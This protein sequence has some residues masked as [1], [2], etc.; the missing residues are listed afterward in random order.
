MANIASLE[1]RYSANI[2]Q[3]DR[4]LKRLQTLNKR[5]TDRVLTDHK[6][7]VRDV[8][9]AWAKADIGGALNKSLGSGLGSLK[10]QLMGSIAAITS[11]AGIAAA[12]GLADTFNRFSNSLKI[13]GA[14]GANL[15]IIQDR[16]FA[17]A[18]RHGVQ[19]ESLGQLYGRV[20]QSAKELGV[21]QNQILTVTDA[22]AAA[23]RVSGQPISAASGAMLQFAQSIGSGTVRAEEFNSMVEG[24][25]PLVQ[26]AA[27]ASSKYTGSV[28]RMRAA[29]LEGKLSSKE[30]F[31]L[32][33]AGSAALEAKA[34]RA[35]LTVAQSF[36]ALKNKLIEAM[37][38]TNATWGL[39]DRLSEALAWLS[40][41][42]DDVA[43]ALGA[44]AIALST[45]LAPAIGRAA[46]AMA[47]NT[48]AMATN[49]VAAIA[50]IP[51]QLAFAAALNGTTRAAAAATFGL[52]LLTSATGIGLVITAVT[53]ALGLFA[54]QSYK[55]AEATR[56]IVD[57]VREKKAALDEAKKAADKARVE[58]GNLSQ[59]EMAA[60]TATASLTGQVDLLTTSYG[61]MAV[62]AK[63][64]RL[65]VLAL[66]FVRADSNAKKLEEEARRVENRVTRR[67]SVPVGSAD[68]RQPVPAGYHE[69]IRGSVAVD[70]AVITA[71]KDAADARAVADATLAE[72]ERVK[73]E[74]AESFA[75]APV[76]STST[77]KG[78]K[79][80]GTSAADRAKNSEE[81]IERAERALRDARRGQAV[82]ASEQYVVAVAALADDK[83]MAV[84]AITRRETEGEITKAA[85]DRLIELENQ[86][87]EARLT[88]A[89]NARQ[90]ELD[91]AALELQRY[92]TDNQIEAAKLDVEELN[93]KASLADNRQERHDYERQALEAQQRADRLMFDAEQKSYALQLKKNEVDQA[94]IDRLVAERETNFVRGQTN[95]TST[96]TGRHK[97]ENGPQNLQEWITS[98]GK[99][100]AAGESFNQKLFAIAE[101]GFNAITSGIT[102]AIMGAKT[103]G[104]AFQDVA[105]SV[106]AALIEM[107][108]KFVFFEMLGRAFGV[109][110]LGRAALGIPTV[111][112]AGG[113]PK[114]GSNAMGTRFWGGGPTSI[115]EKGDEIITLPTGS[116]VIPANLV[117]QAVSARPRG[118]NAPIYNMTTVVNA[119]GA[120]M[121]DHIREEIAQAYVMA[122]RDAKQGTLADLA[123]R[124]RNR[125]R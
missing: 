103:F 57:E 114:V 62:E 52:R 91:E 27:G 108:V 102:D 49:G 117:Q 125:L 63:R 122:V 113:A 79:S 71:R 42:L 46:T 58:T 17:S 104:Q 116:Q 44:L 80:S 36:E 59:A 78:G 25:L 109:P 76:V 7:S 61:R 99:A 45:L 89:V 19:I 107:A 115:N 60:L 51:Q 74:R 43:T 37:G 48:A 41:N 39:T 55:A 13:A 94:E 73:T 82:T 120:V 22:V 33:I 100:E 38:A 18:N 96:Q 85:R 53:V 87:H 110:G 106:I 6:K 123:N 70:P 90:R 88:T 3:F 124:D 67:N 66:E 32:I 30:F 11:G 35:P 72:R 83:E 69:M 28:A 20:S 95:Q 118:N 119:E 56:K 23:I 105:K 64:A 14:E 24:M 84:A 112:G 81:A 93:D 16:L 54:A 86:T 2:I 47:M 50:A 121:R 65:E 92:R 29:V 5:A 9:S 12:V 101:G 98:F 26:A 8:N 77:N 1:A 97:N 68:G 40:N 10:T 34:A 15:T 31:D 21:S 111:S 4:E 75:A